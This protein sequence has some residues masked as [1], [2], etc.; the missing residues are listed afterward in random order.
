MAGATSFYSDEEKL[1]K[2]ADG[3]GMI[4]CDLPSQPE[5]MFE[6]MGTVE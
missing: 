2:L 6:M 4:G 1:R 3:A 5:D